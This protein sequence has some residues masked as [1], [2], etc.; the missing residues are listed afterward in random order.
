MSSGGKGGEW[1]GAVLDA[2]AK[3]LATATAAVEA[4]VSKA[5]AV[6]DEFQ[7]LRDHVEN[8]KS[9]TAE[10]EHGY[11]RLAARMR[12]TER[13]FA[14]ATGVG[15]ASYDDRLDQAELEALERYTET[16]DIGARR[17]R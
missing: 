15:L 7:R 11:V 16:G 14:A 2:A 9:R 4:A 10:L 17:K 3:T 5:E 1:A 6:R 12:S 13:A 8:L